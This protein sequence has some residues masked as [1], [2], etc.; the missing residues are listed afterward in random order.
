MA[1]QETFLVVQHSINS[2]FVRA[3]IFQ[4]SYEQLYKL[5]H[6][7]WHLDI[8]L[9]QADASEAPGVLG[10]PLQHVETLRRVYAVTE[11]LVTAGFHLRQ[12]PE[13]QRKREVAEAIKRI[14]LE[15]DSLVQEEIYPN[16]RQGDLQ[17][18]VDKGIDPLSPEATALLRR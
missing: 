10:Q 1:E 3:F 7:N 8:F 18:L 17:R 11:A 15:A 16:T 2:N 12:L 4:G 14:Q 13:D 5:D 9:L 6:L